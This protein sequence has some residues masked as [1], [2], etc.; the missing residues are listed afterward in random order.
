MSAKAGKAG[1]AAKKTLQVVVVIVS[2]GHIFHLKTCRG[3]EKVVLDQIMRDIDRCWKT[4]CWSS[5]YHHQAIRPSGIQRTVSHHGC[6]YPCPFWYTAF[7]M[8]RTA[9]HQAPPLPAHKTRAL[10]AVPLPLILGGP[11]DA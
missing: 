3:S 1:L 9:V 11:S 6:M 5:K 10:S 2:N 7:V 8:S 4:D